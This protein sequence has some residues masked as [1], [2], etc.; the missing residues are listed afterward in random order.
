MRKKYFRLKRKINY[1]YQERIR[2][3]KLKTIERKLFQA[4]FRLIAGIDEVGRG[5]LAGPVVAAAVIIKDID[6][7][8]ITD[9]KDSKKLNNR[10]REYLSKLI[11]EKSYD[12]GI[13]IIDPDTIDQINIL[14]ATL[15][16]MKRAVM[17]LKYC[18]DYLLVDALNIPFID[19]PQDSIIKGEDK[20]ISIAAASIV[21]K[22]YRDNLMKKVHKQYPLYLFN[23]NMGYGTKNHLIALKIHGI[24]PIHRKSFKGVK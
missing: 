24:C 23:Q 7:F 8:F 18:P 19:I 4:G 20:S 15:L 17:S 13:G 1:L 11:I 21:A 6:S 2:I 14:R 22:V 12:I 10:K 5:A 3:E 9:L 16:A